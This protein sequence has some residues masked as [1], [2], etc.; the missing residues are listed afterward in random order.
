MV[1]DDED[2]EKGDGRDRDHDQEDDPLH[3]CVG[4][5]IHLPFTVLADSPER[6]AAQAP[7][8]PGPHGRGSASGP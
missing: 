4:A 5:L 3:L 6:P 7:I 2:E 1:P 8:N